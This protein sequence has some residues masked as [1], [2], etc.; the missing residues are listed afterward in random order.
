MLLPAAVAAGAGLAGV[1]YGSRTTDARDTRAWTRD[2]RLKAYS[3]LLEAV[4]RCYAAFGLIGSTLDLHRYQVDAVRDPTMRTTIGEWGRWDQKIDEF[5]PRAELV[6]GPSVQIH[7]SVGVR[8]GLR[9]RQRSLLMKLDYSSEVDEAEWRS[10]AKLTLDDMDRVRV[11]L[12][13]DITRRETPPRRL[14]RIRFALRKWRRRVREHM[15][16]VRK[17]RAR[18]SI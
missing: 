13:A 10:V 12:R 5:L 3:D 18:Q 17:S 8:L 2:Q 4:D 6:A 11:M 16:F 14:R 15:A 9:T 7:L 1:Y